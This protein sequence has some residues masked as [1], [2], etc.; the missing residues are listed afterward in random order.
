[1]GQVDSLLGLKPGTARR[2]IDGYERH[3]RQYPPVVRPEAT[4]HEKV[5]WGE[6]VE[7]RLLSEYREAGAPMIKMRPAVERLRE[8]LGTPYPLATV[9]PYV[10]GRELVRRVQQDVGLEPRLQLVVIRNEQLMLSAPAQA[11]YSSAEFGEGDLAPV[12]RL[13]PAPDI[14]AVVIDP[15]RHFGEPVVRSVPTE[16]IAEQV[17][18]GDT[19]G[20]I[21]ELYELDPVDVEAA[22]R[23]ELLRAKPATEEVA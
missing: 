6:F 2:W 10:A 14:T 18:A 9:Q 11:F 12:E 17:R 21:A 19:I 20:M 15:R 4:G 23:Y 13:H 7:A 3:G 16:V 1:M 5:T 8:E 22:V